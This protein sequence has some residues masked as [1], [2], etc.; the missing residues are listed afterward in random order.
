MPSKRFPPTAYRSRSATSVSAFCF[1]LVQ[2]YDQIYDFPLAVICLFGN[3]CRVTLPSSLL[4][5]TEVRSIHTGLISSRFPLLMVDR[6]GIDCCC[7]ASIR[8][9]IYSHPGQ[10]NSTLMSR[11]G[12]VLCRR[13]LS[14]QDNIRPRTASSRSDA[15]CKTDKTPKPER[16]QQRQFHPTLGWITAPSK[17]PACPLLWWEITLEST[18]GYQTGAQK[19]SRTFMPHT[20]SDADSLTNRFFHALSRQLQPLPPAR[21]ES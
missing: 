14:D 2:A 8:S 1:R 11:F 10:G 6:L 9:W 20:R 19:P 18:K 17:F 16:N 12:L 3:S 21:R 13:I 7:C 5:Y 15:N 4:A